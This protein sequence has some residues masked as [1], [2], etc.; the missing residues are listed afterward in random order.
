MAV[1]HLQVGSI[2]CSL[3]TESIRGGLCRLD[4]VR[5]VQVS[6]ADGGSGRVRP[7]AG[8]CREPVCEAPRP[9]LY[10]AGA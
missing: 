6:L 4:G 7:G 3:C 10:R 1:L 5:D 2:H 8:A 9:G